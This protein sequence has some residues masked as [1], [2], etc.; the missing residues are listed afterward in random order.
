VIVIHE[1][2]EHRAVLAAAEAVVELLVG[3]HPEG[4]G[5]LVVERAAG[6]VLAPGLLQLHARADDLHDVGAGDEFVDEVLRN[7]SQV[8]TVPGA[9]ANLH[10][11]SLPRRAR[12]GSRQI[13]RVSALFAH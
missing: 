4:R 12:R 13:S 8:P 7:A 6:L 11:G 10:R 9:Q 2:S 1:E 3:A 5:F